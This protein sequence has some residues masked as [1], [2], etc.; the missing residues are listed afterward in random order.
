MVSPDFQATK[1][2]KTCDA[3]SRPVF[4]SEY[5]FEIALT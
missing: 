2:D 5:Y 4:F 1:R 3:A